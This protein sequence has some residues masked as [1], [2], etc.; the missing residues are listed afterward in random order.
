MDSLMR[1]K[2]AVSRDEVTS[3]DLSQ[4]VKVLESGKSMVWLGSANLFYTIALKKFMPVK[5]S[6]LLTCLLVWMT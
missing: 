6:C 5:Q 1:V 4:A 3:S 2:L